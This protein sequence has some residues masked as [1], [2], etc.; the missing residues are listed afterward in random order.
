M[1]LAITKQPSVR[2][3]TVRPRTQPDCVIQAM[4]HTWFRWR[5]MM[6]LNESLSDRLGSD[7]DS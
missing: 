1:K 4:V 6:H 7:N 2:P 5:T 3:E